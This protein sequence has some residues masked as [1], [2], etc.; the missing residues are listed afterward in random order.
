MSCMTLQL[1]AVAM[2]ATQ[3]ARPVCVE[4]SKAEFSRQIVGPPQL[5]MNWVVVTD[6]DGKQQLRMRWT[7]GDGDRH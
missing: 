2:A 1:K 7:A 6:Q 4:N 5:S 3:F